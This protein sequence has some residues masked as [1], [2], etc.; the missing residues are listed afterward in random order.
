MEKLNS[1]FGI[2]VV[3]AILSSARPT[4]STQAATAS[5]ELSRSGV[6]ALE[7]LDAV[8]FT[9]EDARY[10]DLVNGICEPTE[11]E[12]RLLAQ[13]GFVVTERLS[14][15]DFLHAYAWIYQNDLPVLV[16]TDAMLHALHDAYS[17]L[18]MRTEE[19]ILFPMIREILVSTRANLPVNSS[20]D[21]V[22][23]A[24]YEDVDTYLQVGLALLNGDGPQAFPLRISEHVDRALKANQ[25]FNNFGLFGVTR[26][27]DF[28]RFKPTGHYLR[29]L[30]SFNDAL[31]R[32]YRAM[33]WLALVDFPLLVYDPSGTP[34]VYL[35]PLGA[36][37][38]LRNAMDAAGTRAVWDELETI[39]VAMFGVSDNVTL[40]DLDRFLVDAGIVTAEQAVAANPDDLLALLSTNNY[41]KQRIS[42]AILPASVSGTE[43]L[44]QPV[45][46]V[47]LG[48][49]FALDSYVM[50]QLVFDQL[51]VNGTMVRRAF[52]CGLDVMAALGSDRAVTHLEEELNKY[53]YYYNLGQL[54]NHV[55]WL[56]DGFWTQTMYNGWLNAVRALNVATTELI[57]P[58]CMQTAAWAD[59]ALH[60]Q[61]ASWAQLRYDTLLYI[62][63]S[64]TDLD[65]C[66]YPEGYVEPYPQF[67][68]RLDAYARLGYELFDGLVVEGDGAALRQKTL[69]YFLHLQDVANRLQVMAE[70][71]LRLE[72]FSDEEAQFLKEIIVSQRTHG[73]CGRTSKEW[74]GWYA[75][76]FPWYSERNLE[77]WSVSTP[78]VV[79]QVHTNPNTQFILPP[80]VLHVGTGRVATILL[81]ADKDEGQTIY[82]GPGL[83]YYEFINEGYP[84]ERLS[85][86]EWEELLSGKSPLPPPSWTQTFRPID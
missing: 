41:G 58:Q 34:W 45:S 22:Q 19:H 70:K 66:D 55:S 7:Y 11:D 43:P 33:M 71:E 49:R 30:F 13:N 48:Q 27:I 6:E 28:T 10:F 18:L 8:S 2:L 32:Y 74:D 77:D 17:D 84:P 4:R 50:S 63:Q 82:V 21:P 51:V 47:L 37:T 23:V 81:I 25:V 65:V 69:S 86:D 20:N 67:Y 53:G 39:L 24:I 60:T 59:K 15:R 83:T 29:P 79:A 76:L 78:Y 73:T 56:N 40:P 61:L 9:P 35:E 44:P 3:A 52:P 80:G 42:G 12:M 38:L 72:P 36:A 5:D 46:F 85:N 62:K 14:Y 16:S 57:Y 31:E 1:L 68:V 75:G 54:R 26:T 64:Y